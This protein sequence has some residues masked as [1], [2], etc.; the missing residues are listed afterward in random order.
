MDYTENNS[1]QSSTSKRANLVSEL[2]KTNIDAS[3]D[4][5]IIKND[6]ILIPTKN[7]NNYQNLD[8]SKSCTVTDNTIVLDISQEN[9]KLQPSSEFIKTRTPLSS[10]QFNNKT[11]N[12]KTL[13][14]P[15]QPLKSGLCSKS[16][17]NINNSPKNAFNS[18]DFTSSSAPLDRL[19]D[20]S[21]AARYT[22][23]KGKEKR[24]EI[25]ENSN[26]LISKNSGKIR[27]FFCYSC[28]SEMSIVKTVKPKC[29][30]CHSVFIIQIDGLNSYEISE[31]LSSS[32][33]E[34]YSSDNK[35]NNTTISSYGYSNESLLSK[36]RPNADTFLDSL[37]NAFFQ[38]QSYYSSLISEKNKIL[39]SQPQ[40]ETN[41]HLDSLLS[42]IRNFEQ[43]NNK[44]SEEDQSILLG[45]NYDNLDG[46]TQL[47]SRL[48]DRI[49]VLINAATVII[50]QNNFNATAEKFKNFL[51]EST[52]S[53]SYSGDKMDSE[54]IDETSS[55]KDSSSSS[56]PGSFFMFSY[57]IPTIDLT[58][59][60][61]L[62]EVLQKIYL[63]YKDKYSTS[64]YLGP[65][66]KS[67]YDR[68]YDSAKA[69]E[70]SVS[71]YNTNSN[72]DT[73]A[74]TSSNLDNINNTYFNLLP[75]F[76]FRDIDSFDDNPDFAEIY[77]TT[78]QEDTNSTNN[79]KNEHMGDNDLQDLDNAQSNLQTGSRFINP[80]DNGPLN[81]SNLF[82]SLLG[83]ISSDGSTSLNENET[84]QTTLSRHRINQVNYIWNSRQHIMND[85]SLDMIISELILN[86]QE[87]HYL[88]ASVEETGSLVR[89]FHYDLK[90]VSKECS[91]CL[92]DYNADSL[93]IELD[94]EHIF[95]EHCILQWLN[96]NGNCPVCR[97]PLT[98]YHNNNT[99]TNSINNTSLVASDNE[100]INNNTFTNSINN[101]NSS[102][103]AS[104]NEQ[105]NNNTKVFQ[106]QNNQTDSPQNL[107]ETLQAGNS[108]E[109][110]ITYIMGN[111]NN[112]AIINRSETNNT[113]SA[114]NETLLDSHNEIVDSES[115]PYTALR[116]NNDSRNNEN[117]LTP[118]NILQNVGILDQS[119]HRSAINDNLDCQTTVYSDLNQDFNQEHS[120][121]N[122]LYQNLE[123]L[124][125]PGSFPIQ[126]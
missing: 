29:A 88:P 116:S 82:N 48:M 10:I 58:A 32:D 111:T 1:K 7:K 52:Q 76:N 69:L 70:P 26:N 55:E 45:E 20:Y 108:L 17:I 126:H 23:S 117:N 11:I 21:S 59:L 9:L 122:D 16:G 67:I 115:Q 34:Y 37:N 19:V 47:T 28:Q 63:K 77:Q 121:Y 3:P 50:N 95:H 56:V 53:F 86:T 83:S 119:S 89:K 14:N 42:K 120:D 81:L 109:P 78:E 65:H 74:S 87:A 102:L 46:F 41:S 30:Q 27:R 105:I 124:K 51:H 31:P 114:R 33:E 44:Q 5:E 22:I 94:C 66:S 113:C 54:D 24:I 91:V 35:S 36:L 6:Y 64:E 80:E 43:K 75:S 18:A 112:I 98:K 118:S 106:N 12:T 49:S 71:K 73:A 2:N 13:Y 62:T 39:Q 92:D 25:K 110:N 101:N 60:D 68:L 93:V 100:Q 103:V 38:I 8:S 99:F 57:N 96:I 125:I 40:A 97:K 4:I 79:A 84:A 72:I 123:F 85:Q 107:S 15:K 104:D 61:N 90:R